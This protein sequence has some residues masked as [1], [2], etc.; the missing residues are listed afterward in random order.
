MSHPARNE[1]N[2][3]PCVFY[4]RE[5]RLRDSPAAREGT[6]GQGRLPL[7]SAI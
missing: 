4:D 3:S 7:L 6:I 2:R 5:G 1:Q